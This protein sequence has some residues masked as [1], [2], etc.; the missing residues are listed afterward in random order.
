[1]E[2]KNKPAKTS[3]EIEQRGVGK[4]YEEGGIV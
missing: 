3:K 2:L 1:M 4:S